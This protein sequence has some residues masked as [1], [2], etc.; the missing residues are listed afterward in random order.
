MTRVLVS[1]GEAVLRDPSTGVALMYGKANIDSAFT[2]AAT[3][4]EV[5]GG[6]NNQLLF[7]YIH[8]KKVSVKITDAT[9]NMDL[10]SLN[11][12]TSVLNSSITALKTECVTFSASGSATLANVPTGAKGV[13]VFIGDPATIQNVTP[14]GSV[15]TVSGGNSLTGTAIYEYSVTADQLTVEAATP[16]TIVDLTLTAQERDSVT[17][18]VVN[19][20]QIHI[21]SFQVLGNYTLTM[22]ANGVS[23]QPLE[24]DALLT[25][26]TNCT[27]NDYYAQI[28]RIPYTGT[29]PSVNNMFLSKST[30]I[31]VAAGLPKNVQLQAIGLRGG[32]NSY[33]DVTTSASYHVTSGS[34]TLP[35]YF[36]VG[37]N[38]GL[39]TAGSS[40]AAGWTAVITGCY[41]DT[42]SGT[43]TD[44]AI[45]TVTA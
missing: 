14:V 36:S 26:S 21:P 13:N 38:T 1:V 28:T 30:S 40:V 3:A 15:I 27:V 12:G 44:T 17:K 39:V 29:N 41:V 37:A 2:M 20:V 43:L 19:L 25:K 16:P 35:S 23:N 4:T 33:I 45:I 6:I 11:A 22:T 31:S 32:L 24:G 5:R 7:T 42:V 10:L 8:D 18:G 9:F 34:V